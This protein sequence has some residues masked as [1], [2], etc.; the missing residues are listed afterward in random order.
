MILFTPKA[1]AKL[2]TYVEL[3]DEEISGL[4]KV[5]ILNDDFIV[6][7][8]FLLKQESS[9]SHT[10]LDEAAL[11]SFLR[12]IVA[13]GED[14]SLYQL[15]WHSHGRNS[16]FWSSI[17][18]ETCARFGNE[19]MLSLCTNK[20]HQTLAR[21]DV[22]RPVHIWAELDVGVY[23]Q[24]DER[25][26]ELLR[27]E[28]QEKVRRKVWSWSWPRSRSRWDWVGDKDKEERDHYGNRLY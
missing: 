13:Q 16:V 15:W 5:S 8:V 22:Y 25:E 23:T 1:M 17:D 10:E 20:K 12:K 24:L 28:L 14:P 18:M 3:S 9:W 26:R 21:L 6:S 4:G 27:E 7:E 2:R 11:S 19:W